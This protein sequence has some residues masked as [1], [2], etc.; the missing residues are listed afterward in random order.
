MSNPMH[1]TGDTWI[2]LTMWAASVLLFFVALAVTDAI[3]TRWDRSNR[4]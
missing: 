2:D 1:S 4:R 3:A